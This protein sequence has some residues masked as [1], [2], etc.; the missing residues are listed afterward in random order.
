MTIENTCLPLEP[1]NAHVQ[2]PPIALPSI[3]QHGT[4][5]AMRHA[6]LA[7]VTFLL[8]AGSV[9]AQDLDPQFTPSFNNAIRAMARQSD[10]SV[11]VGGD[12]TT[13]NGQDRYVLA[14]VAA[15]GALLAAPAR[16]D[17]PV[18][19][20]A[21]DSSGRILVGG[22]LT[23]L[24]TH[25][26]PNIGRLNADG[27][28][29]TTFVSGLFDGLT[30]VTAIYVLPNGKIVVTGGLDTGPESTRMAILN[31]DGSVN[32]GFN[33]P[34][35]PAVASLAVTSDNRMIVAANFN[36]EDPRCESYCVIRVDLNGAIDQSFSA[37][38]VGPVRHMAM[39]AGGR[40][41]VT[42]P[43]GKVDEHFTQSVGRIMPSGGADTSFGNTGILYANMD[44][45]QPQ[46]DGTILVAG[47]FR[48][49]QA[50]TS[51]DRIGRLGSS[52]AH[53]TTYDDPQFDSSVEA[54][55]SLP[56][57]GLVVGGFFNFANGVARNHIARF[58][59]ASPDA[60]YANGFD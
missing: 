44:L 36:D 33:Q 37:T 31:A 50:G 39:D 3:R 17:R 5:S 20:L 4:A 10:G 43:F 2:H 55:S 16:P 57:M 15:N 54:F 23:R 58:G 24:G 49:Q 6:W 46:A 34:D 45:V 27:T 52:G 35:W 18:K 11:V 41:L 29:D 40:I 28:V 8:S 48:W 56:N 25:A 9:T 60:V 22:K 21:V 59:A 38:M 14:R 12:F 32:P 42:G 19:A 7:V 1:C 30:G 13:V 51:V 53:D 47:E 26:T